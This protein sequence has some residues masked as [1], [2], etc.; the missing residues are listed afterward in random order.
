VMGT[1]GGHGQPLTVATWY[2]LDGDELLVNLDASRARLKYLQ[3]G[4][5]YSL[6]A[7]AGDDWYSHVSVQ[8]SVSRIVEDAEL[9]D[10]D[11]ISTHYTGHEYLVR[12][13][14]RVSVWCSLERWHGW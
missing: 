7:L 5:E 2:V 14:E 13:R 4:C 12:D 6:T 10:I 1:L 8:G 3:P 11:R 9:V